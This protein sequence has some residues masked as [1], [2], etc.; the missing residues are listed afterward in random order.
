MD[1]TKVSA[2]LWLGSDY[3]VTGNKQVIAVLERHI[4][5]RIHIADFSDAQYFQESQLS[6][7]AATVLQYKTN[8]TARLS[9]NVIATKKFLIDT[10]LVDGYAAR[11]EGTKIEGFA[12]LNNYTILMANDNDF[13]LEANVDDAVDI[14]RF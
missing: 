2:A 13:G 6:V 9:K 10:A 5:V 8:V 1:S 4:S 11:S 12:F 3:G 7:A 14:I